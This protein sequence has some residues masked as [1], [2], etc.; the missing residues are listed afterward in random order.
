M[1]TQ[2]IERYTP[3]PPCL[4]I[5]NIDFC[6]QAIDDALV[7]PNTLPY[8]EGDYWPNVIEDC[9]RDAEKEEIEQRKKEENATNADDDDEDFFQTDDGRPVKKNNK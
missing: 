4:L 5:I 8:F 3:L 2:F 1:I 7:A 6:F 9:I